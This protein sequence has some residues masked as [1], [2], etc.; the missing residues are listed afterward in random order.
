MPVGTLLMPAAFA[1]RMTSSGTAVVCDVDVA[2]RASEQCVADR[3]AY[4]ARFLAV[5]D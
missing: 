3:T 5:A 2:D 4:H 1:R